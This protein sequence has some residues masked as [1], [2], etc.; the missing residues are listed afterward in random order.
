MALTRALAL[1]LALTLPLSIL[2][3]I[4]ILV[5]FS[6]GCRVPQTD[7]RIHLWARTPG[8]AR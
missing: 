1:T 3:Q 4:T 5:A 7:Y 6:V 2:A 8:S